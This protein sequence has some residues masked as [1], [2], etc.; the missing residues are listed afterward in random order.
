MDYV[1][2]PGRQFGQEVVLARERA[3]ARSSLPIGYH[4]MRP[5]ELNSFAGSISV[6]QSVVN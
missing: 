3:R 4:N 2:T 6:Q 1:M 5:L